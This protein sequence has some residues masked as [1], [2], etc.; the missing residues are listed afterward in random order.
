MGEKY[1]PMTQRCN[2]MIV[3]CYQLVCL[4]IVDGTTHNFEAST[5]RTVSIYSIK[6]CHNTYM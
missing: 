4:V 6:G 5:V 2:Q 3:P 1:N